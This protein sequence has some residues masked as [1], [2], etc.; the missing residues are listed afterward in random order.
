M[1]N[2]QTQGSPDAGADTDPATDTEE[3]QTVAFGA[4]RKAEGSAGSA[5][6]C[7][8]TYLC[9]TFVLTTHARLKRSRAIDPFE[10][11]AMVHSGATGLVDDWRTKMVS[12]YGTASPRSL[13][14]HLRTPDHNALPCSPMSS[15]SMTSVSTFGSLNVRRDCWLPLVMNS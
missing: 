2:D 10:S 1:R 13:T 11:S 6:R 12:P 4:K 8:L 3:I 9:S 15:S 7:V 5:S 14:L